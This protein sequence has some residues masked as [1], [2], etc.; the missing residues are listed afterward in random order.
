[1]NG[2]FFSYTNRGLSDSSRLYRK[3]APRQQPSVCED[4]DRAF[5]VG[6]L[7][8]TSAPRLSNTVNENGGVVIMVYRME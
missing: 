6:P 4:A 7:Y 2:A 1:M 8:R 3:N 5:R